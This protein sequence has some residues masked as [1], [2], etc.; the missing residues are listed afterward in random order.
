VADYQAHLDAHGY[1]TIVVGDDSQR[2]KSP[3][4]F[5]SAN[6]LSFGRDQQS[7]LIYRQLIPARGFSQALP[8]PTSSAS[9]LQPRM[10][11]YYPTMTTC[12]A[13]DWAAGRCRAS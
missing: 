7:V 2:Q 12:A 5:R 6:W 3:A 8:R 11:P 4:A 13:S 10:G 9:G 1:V